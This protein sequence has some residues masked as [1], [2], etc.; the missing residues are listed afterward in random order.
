MLQGHL[1]D[2]LG[3]QSEE[4]WGLVRGL[5]QQ[6]QHVEAAVSRGPA[7]L[8]AELREAG[9]EAGLRD[10]CVG[11]LPS[12]VPAR[13]PSPYFLTPPRRGL[14]DRFPLLG[15]CAPTSVISTLAGSPRT[16]PSCCR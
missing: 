10:P 2:Q 1:E 3:G 4:F 7:V 9:R 13:D 11:R 8:D 12:F 15:L 16:E 6:G 5:E 14:T